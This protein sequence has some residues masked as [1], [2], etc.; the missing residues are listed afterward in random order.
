MKR[1]SVFLWLSLVSL[2]SVS[3]FAQPSPAQQKRIDKAIKDAKNHTVTDWTAF[4][5]PF[6]GTGKMQSK[7]ESAR[8][9]KYC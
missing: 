7:V 4:V 2:D 5:S 8:P 3:V 6:I 9:L 1:L